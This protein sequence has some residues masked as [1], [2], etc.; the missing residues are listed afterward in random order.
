MLAKVDELFVHEPLELHQKNP[1]CMV[2]RCTKT[3]KVPKKLRKQA[4]L[5]KVWDAYPLGKNHVFGLPETEDSKTIYFGHLVC[6]GREARGKGLGMEMIK[7]SHKLAEKAGCTHTY[8]I[9]T[10]KFSQRIFQK[11]GYQ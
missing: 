2:A 7:R 5:Q 9:A 4:T 3:G 8:I 1:A 10:G 11:L 6:V